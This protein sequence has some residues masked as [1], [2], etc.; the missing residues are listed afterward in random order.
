MCDR[1]TDNLRDLNVS[2]SA[3]HGDLPQTSREKALK[4]F[5]NGE[6][7]VL[8]ATDVAARGL[9]VD[10]ITL[11]VN[12]DILGERLETLRGLGVKSVVFDEAPLFRCL[13]CGHGWDD[14]ED[15]G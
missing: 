15:H 6:L 13:A 7:R 12:Y 2:A 11:V 4:R 14:H 5:T 8:V 10:R 1:V 3:I 9:D